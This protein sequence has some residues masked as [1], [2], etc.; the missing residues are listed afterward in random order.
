L[1]HCE[2]D[3][4]L[5]PAIPIPG[6]QLDTPERDTPP[7]TSTKTELEDQDCA[8]NSERATLAV[9][10]AQSGRKDAQL[11]GWDKSVWTLVGSQL[12][13]VGDWP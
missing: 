6:V 11:A 5:H 9:S 7:V 1:S 13:E 10:P 3:T 2:L 4:T 8:D 12:S